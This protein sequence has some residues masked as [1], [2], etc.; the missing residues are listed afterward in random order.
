MMINGP[1]KIGPPIPEEQ[2]EEVETSTPE[3]TDTD[4]TAHVTH[5]DPQR[6]DKHDLTK[7]VLL[8]SAGL[9]NFEDSSYSNG[10]SHD[11]IEWYRHSAGIN[12]TVDSSPT[13]DKAPE[14]QRTHSEHASQNFAQA[15][16]LS[17][18]IVHW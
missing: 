17:S 12:L 18:L 3:R 13:T 6:W 14:L 8:V 15:D 16:K 11:F 2:E 10:E 5:A 7:P 4:W 1:W 9:L